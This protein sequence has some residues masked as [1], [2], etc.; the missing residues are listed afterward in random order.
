M[1][2]SSYNIWVSNQKCSIFCVLSRAIN[3]KLTYLLITYSR[4]SQTF[5]KNFDFTKMCESIK[6]LN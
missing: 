2:D 6:T 4:Q 1:V 3:Y 5:Y